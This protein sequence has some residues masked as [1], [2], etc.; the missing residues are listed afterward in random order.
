LTPAQQMVGEGEEEAHVEQV[1]PEEHEARE[2]APKE[3]DGSSSED[4]GDEEG[5]PHG[6]EQQ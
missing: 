1:T 4:D 3:Q 2:E 5:A 6:G